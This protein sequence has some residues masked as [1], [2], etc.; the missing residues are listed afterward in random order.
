MYPPSSFSNWTRSISINQDDGFSNA[1]TTTPC[2]SDSC[3]LHKVFPENE[4]A[5]LKLGPDRPASLPEPELHPESPLR[6]PGHVTRWRGPSP[7]R[8]GSRGPAA[9][10]CRPRPRQGGAWRSP[11]KWLSGA[12]SCWEGGG[13]GPGARWRCGREVELAAA[14]PREPAQ[15]PPGEAG[16]CEE[17]DQDAPRRRRGPAPATGGRRLWRFSPAPTPVPWKLGLREKGR[18][19]VTG[20]EGADGAWAPDSC[21]LHSGA[22]GPSGEETG[23]RRG[24]LWRGWQLAG[25]VKEGPRRLASSPAVSEA[26]KDFPFPGIHQGLGKIFSQSWTGVSK[27]YVCVSLRTLRLSPS[28]PFT[29][30][31]YQKQENLKTFAFAKELL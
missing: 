22:L 10:P 24:S 3:V 17:L 31:T 2:S 20:A 4:S 5:P 15:G 26:A 29:S 14:G 30:L 11:R 19:P 13:G 28:C 7:R 18:P 27:I 16:G 21:P 6:R 23:R 9:P 12:D 8:W 25:W 1:G